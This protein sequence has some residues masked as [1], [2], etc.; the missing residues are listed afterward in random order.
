MKKQNSISLIF[1]L[2]MLLIAGACSSSRN[3]AKDQ[4]SDKQTTTRVKGKR[5]DFTTQLAATYSDW[6]DLNAPLSINIS[7]PIKFGFSARATMV[8]G[9]SIHLSMRMLGMEVAV[10]HVD[11]DSAWV[12]DKYHKYICSLPTS[13]LTRNGRFSLS[14]VQ[15]LLLGRAFYPG[16]GTLKSEGRTAE[17]FSIQE[18]GDSVVMLPRKIPGDT[19]WQLLANSTPELELFQV[20]LSDVNSIQIGFDNFVKTEAGST[21]SNIEVLGI[22]DEIGINANLT[23]NFGKAKWNEGK[24]SDWTPPTDFK[25]LSFNELIKAFKAQ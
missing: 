6:T 21:A 1:C 3:A 10:A 17:L 14:D 8:R 13:S 25:R 11:N 2:A 15:D 19:P 20:M 23:W 5:F 24:D 7:A 4:Q 9:E 18:Y 22:I 16:I 12:V